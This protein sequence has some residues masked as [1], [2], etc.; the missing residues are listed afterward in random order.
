M[1]PFDPE[2]L[3]IASIQWEPL[4]PLIAAANRGL[5]RYDGILAGL[6]NPELLPALWLYR[7]SAALGME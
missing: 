7:L 4:I 5:A 1:T 2:P 6:P 3:P